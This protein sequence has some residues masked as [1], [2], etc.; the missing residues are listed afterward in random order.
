MSPELFIASYEQ[1]L[2]SQNWHKVS[3]L[4]SDR[5]CVTFSN[6]TVHRGK[7]KVKAAFENNFAKIKSEKYEMHNVSWLTINDSYAVYIFK[8]QWTG[9]IDDKNHSGNG[10]GTSVIIKEDNNWKL[11]TEH[12]GSTHQIK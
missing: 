10:V 4:I 11:L 5:V 9:I 12:L 8:Y 7:E 2:A 1:A 6:G 3:P